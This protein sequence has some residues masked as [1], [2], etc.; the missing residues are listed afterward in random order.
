VRTEANTVPVVE[1]TRCS[2]AWQLSDLRY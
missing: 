1:N 2:S